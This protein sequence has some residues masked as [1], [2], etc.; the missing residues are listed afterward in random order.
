VAKKAAKK[1]AKKSVKK[2]VKK[3]VKKPVKKLARKRPATG[4]SGSI[5]F[6]PAKTEIGSLKGK[7]QGV[8]ATQGPNLTVQDIIDKIDKLDAALICQTIMTPT[9]P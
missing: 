6:G 4:T 9:F 1:A 5:S 3:T 2:T 8:I 7:L